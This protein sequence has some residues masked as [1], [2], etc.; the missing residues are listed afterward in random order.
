MKLDVAIPVKA[1][2]FNQNLETLLGASP[3]YKFHEDFTQSPKDRVFVF[4]SNL[5]GFH[6]A[7][8]AWAAAQYYGAARG[9]GEG[10]T[11][12]CYAI[13][14][15]DHHIQ[16]L[17]IEEVEKAVKRFVHYT[18]KNPNKLFFVTRIGCGLAGFTDEQ[19]A[20]MFHGAINCSFAQEWKDYLTA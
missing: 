3:A 1:P 18:H 16:T 5:A 2:R 11:G 19:I 20:P 17:P 13:P 6:G 15:K 12:S 10:P 8:A 14:T 9:I 4:G 7:G